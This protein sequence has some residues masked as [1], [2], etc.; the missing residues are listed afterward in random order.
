MA[1][2]NALVSTGDV[3]TW[4]SLK[5]LCRIGG[6]SADWVV[7]LVEQGILEPAGRDRATWRFHSSSLGVVTRVRRLQGDLGINL[8]GV[9]VVLALVEENARLKRRLQQ[10]DRET[11]LAIWMPAA[12][13]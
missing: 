2:D 12:K 1:A 7:E 13:I 11:A 8:A 6:C 5:Q 10:L 3:V 4:V 9:A